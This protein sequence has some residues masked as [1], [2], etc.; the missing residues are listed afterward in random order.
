M[1]LQY[2]DAG[3]YP[4]II[5]R[6]WASCP[7][8]SKHFNFFTMQSLH[9]LNNV[10]RAKLLFDLLPAD[11]PAFVDFTKTL[12]E[13]VKENPEALR[14][15][16]QTP[17]LNVDMW[18]KLAY[19]VH[20][21]IEKYGSKL[22]RSGRL[23]SDQLFDGYLALFSVHCLQQFVQYAELKERRFKTAVELFF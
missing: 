18:V 8:I 1:A 12:A 23:F 10:Q 3:F 5:C 7:A 19:A 4:V 21:A 17:L 6:V 22:S 9:N 20:D 15:K 11:I 14:E 16:W 2:T 13:R